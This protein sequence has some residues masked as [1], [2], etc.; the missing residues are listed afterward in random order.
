MTLSEVA[1]YFNIHRGTLYR[2]VHKGEVPCF[3]IGSDYR[4]N[5][6]A[7][8]KWMVARQIKV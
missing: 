4:F 6:D 7:I 3:K 5:K 2:L 8:E 1:E